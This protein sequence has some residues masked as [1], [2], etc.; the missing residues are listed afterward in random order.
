MTDTLAARAAYTL[1]VKHSRFIVHAA[2]V[3]A[4]DTPQLPD[5]HSTPGVAWLVVAAPVPRT[6]VREEFKV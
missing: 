1:E 4:P 2:A 3:A 5:F 6:I